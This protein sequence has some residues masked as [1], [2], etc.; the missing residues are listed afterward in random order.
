MEIWEDWCD[1]ARRLTGQIG[2]DNLQVHIEAKNNPIEVWKTLDY[3]FNK[4]DDVFSYYLENKIYDI[5]PKYFDRI[6]IYS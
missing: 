5:D 6:V 2:S 3:L 4:N 1:Q